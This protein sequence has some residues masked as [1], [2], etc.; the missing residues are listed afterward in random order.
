MNPNVLRLAV[1]T[2]ESHIT[3]ISRLADM[4]RRVGDHLNHEQITP[5]LRTTAESLDALAAD[6]TDILTALHEQ[7][8]GEDTTTAAEDTTAAKHAAS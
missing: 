4:A 3:L 6:A 7:Q 8:D 5:D 1:A 2:I